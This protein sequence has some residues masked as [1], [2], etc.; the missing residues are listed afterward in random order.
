ME[1]SIEQQTEKKKTLGVSVPTLIT[2]LHTY[3]QGVDIF[4]VFHMRD[5]EIISLL[6]FSHLLIVH[7]PPK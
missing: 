1:G 3:F 6:H 4:C 7:V 5:S 2:F